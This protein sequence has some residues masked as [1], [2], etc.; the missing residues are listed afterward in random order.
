M[1]NKSF[2]YVFSLLSRYELTFLFNFCREH[3]DISA[4]AK[5]DLLFN[6]NPELFEKLFRIGG[7]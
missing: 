5:V 1:A 7:I 6:V 3:R 4:P 2:L